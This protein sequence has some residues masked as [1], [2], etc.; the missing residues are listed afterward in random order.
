V[1]AEHGN[2]DG[3]GPVRAGQGGPYPPAT[4]GHH[5]ATRT[6]EAGQHED[7]AVAAERA[8][9]AARARGADEATREQA[10]EE[11]TEEV[12]PSNG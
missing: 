12:L 3:A 6:G 9:R 5:E 1:V 11:A 8:G 7:A 2:G 10:E 4:D